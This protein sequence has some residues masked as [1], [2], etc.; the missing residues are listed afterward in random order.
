[1]LTRLSLRLRIFLFFALIAFGG[2]ALVIA[3]L[4]VGYIRLGEAHALNSFVIAGLVAVFAIGGLT[5]WIWVLF[6]EHVARPVERLA[7]D[8]RARAHSDV[9]QGIDHQIARYLG[10]LAP[11][12][13]AV[14]A[15]L[16]ET[17]NAMALAVGR[18]TARLAA[19]KTRLETLLA[20]VPD[21]VLF[22]TP[23][24][25]IALYNGHCR[26][27]LGESEALGLGRPVSG[28]LRMGPIRQAYD[29][30]AARDADEGTDILVTTRAGARLLEARLRLLRLEGQET[31]GPGYVLTLRDVTADLK[32]QAERAHLLNRLFD[33]VTAAL[34]D[35]PAGH[36]LAALAQETAARKTAT[37]TEWWPMEALAAE[38][39]G[40]GLAA[41]LDRKGVPLGADLGDTRLRCD[42]FAITRMLERLAL[43]WAGD[44]ASGLILTMA[45]E[46]AEAAVLSLEAEGKAPAAD[47]LAHWLDAPLSPGLSGF[48]GADVLLSHG[49]RLSP[50]PAGPGRHALRLSLPLA[51]PHAAG[52][53][54]VVM[55]DFDLLNAEIPED[56]AAARLK[57][58][59][60]VIFDTETTG[61][62]PQVDEVC[63]I[64]AVRVVN[65][66]IV[67]GERFDML[68][69]PGRKI[70]AASTAVHH[71]TNEMV[72]GAPPVTEALRR[73]H[74]FAEGSVLVAHNA[75]FDMSF[76]RRREAEIGKRFDQ[77]I[78][79]TVLC[80]A[81]LYGQSAEHTLDALC[82]RLHIRIPEEARHTAIGDAIGTA[83]AF[84]K[85][86]PMLEAAELPNLGALIKAFDRHSRLIEH[87]N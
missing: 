8:L 42:G 23:S 40:A 47:T 66:R 87:L 43:D 44:G 28:L 53:T 78:L 14:A 61:L 59:S 24:H 19:E 76:L 73:F 1:M 37:D 82:D 31:E 54:R 35:L 49:T 48:S 26:D 36:P 30:L 34:P 3:G 70:P 9:D 80:S 60:F 62:N 50:E 75:P 32:V 13:D 65:G 38:D 39:L 72:A 58:L 46:G 71:I 17:R 41:R 12:A 51:E 10:D 55:Y 21:G 7:A 16:T 63:Q 84:R 2:S 67:A 68:V 11:A 20:E 25:T 56:L 33:G 29:R 4:T 79:D 5:A 85:M 52:P 6:D 74:A 81:I 57:S 83:E 27:I 15:N 18:E 64:A 69:N 45:S 86:I 77:P 22:C